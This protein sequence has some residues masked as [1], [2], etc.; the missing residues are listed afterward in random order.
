MK[1]FKLLFATL[2][3]AFLSVGC[4]G[5]KSAKSDGGSGGGGGT[6]YSNDVLNSFK[7]FRGGW[8]SPGGANWDYDMTIN[9]LNYKDGQWEV[10]TKYPD[11]LCGKTGGLTVAQA[12]DLIN[13]YQQLKLYK[14]T[15]P[16]LPDAGVEYIEITT[17]TGAVRKFYFKSGT[18]AIPKDEL[19]ASNPEALRDYLQSL[20]KS[21]PTVCQ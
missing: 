2:V 16:A 15:E 17:S 4:K 21:L 6:V 3:I 12:N 10:N 20:Y 8:L 18:T 19:Y 11:P 9:F 7:Y 5:S 14:A 1:T 13:L